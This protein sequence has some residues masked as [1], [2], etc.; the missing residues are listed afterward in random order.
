MCYILTSAFYRLIGKVNNLPKDLGRGPVREL[1]DQSLD[2]RGVFG[3]GGPRHMVPSD[4]GV[5]AAKRNKQV[6]NGSRD[7]LMGHGVVC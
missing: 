6:H 2:S 7:G 5:Q 1:T 3:L 4:V